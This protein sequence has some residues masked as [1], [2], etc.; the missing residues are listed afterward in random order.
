MKIHAHL[1][2]ATVAMLGCNAVL[3]LAA[4][5]LN[6]AHVLGETQCLQL[7]SLK[8]PATAIGLPTQGSLVT[9]A[10]WIAASGSGSTAID[11]HCMV[12]AK[13]MPVDPTAP[14]IE[15]QL[16]LP[17]NWN[18]KVVMLGGGGFDGVIPKVDGNFQVTPAN[19]PTPLARGYAVFGSD[20]GHQA[21]TRA[22]GASVSNEDAAFFS[23]AEAYRNYIGDALKKTRDAALIVVKAAY[24]YVPTK[25]Y[26]FGGSKGGQEALTVAGRWPAD[27]DGIVALYPARNYTLTMM[28][29]LVVSQAL[30]APGAYLNTA[31]RGILYQAALAACDELDGIKDGVISNVPR[32]YASFN[33]ATASLKSG[34]TL[35]CPGGNDAGDSCL[36]DAQLGALQKARSPV[37]FEYLAGGEQKSFLGY[38]ILTSDLGNSSQ[39]P[40]EA[41]VAG[42]T[43]GATPPTFPTGIGN[44]YAV[45]VSDY[46]IRLAVAKDPT[47]D[48]LT[49]NLANPGPL[50]ARLNELYSLDQ[51]DADLSA[52]AKRGGK[53]LIMQG[54]DDMLI[55]PRSTEA[56][57]QGLR[58]TM[59]AGLFD[60]FLRYYEVPGFGHSLSTIFSVVWDQLPA[61]ESWVE[62][63]ADPARNQIVTDTIG[64]P[65]RTR[66][67]C[68]YP[69]WPK[70]AGHGDI[71][72]AASF[73]CVSE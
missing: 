2:I 60:S 38:N 23:N 48:Q 70:Y 19:S 10:Q 22:P 41:F 73:S 8:I 33:P 62:K 14:N 65:G 53:L 36:S 43:I 20:S 35:R 66:P 69:T 55:S 17:K 47:F 24:G 44:S 18:S 37:L 15:W 67:L 68:L 56:Y 63:G 27:W 12:S 30:A 34:A 58:K 64:V 1:F 40:M 57:V 45:T 9:T 31:K 50:T 21:Q 61:I 5:R 49:L 54:S 16:A 13:I 28:G 59:G 72:A 26:F 11:A 52:F 7:A 25:S 3:A 71:N 6:S 51:V 46:F 29:A 4:A 39:S 32:C 42:L